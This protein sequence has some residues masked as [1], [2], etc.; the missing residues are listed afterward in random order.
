[1]LSGGL[2]MDRSCLFVELPL[3]WSVYKGGTKPAA[4]QKV[5][6]TKCLTIGATYPI[7]LTCIWN[8]CKD[9]MSGK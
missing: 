5:L 3:G 8:S 6:G 4:V 7:S 2:Y 9:P 1:M